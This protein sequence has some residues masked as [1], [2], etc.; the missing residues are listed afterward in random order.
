MQNRDRLTT[1]ESRSHGLPERGETERR[2]PGPAMAAVTPFSAAAQA[3]LCIA[4][5]NGAAFA[6]LRCAPAAA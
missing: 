6:I 2:P 3:R 1:S 5:Q 4:I